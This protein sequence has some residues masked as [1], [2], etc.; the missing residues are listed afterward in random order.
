MWHSCGL[1][2]KSSHSLTCLNT[3]PKLIGLFGRGQTVRKWS[4]AEGSRSLRVCV[5]VCECVYMHMC[6]H[7]CTCSGLVTQLYFL[8]MIY[9]LSMSAAWLISLLL[10]PSFLRCLL[11]FLP[12]HD[13]LYPSR[14]VSQSK[15][16]L[17][18]VALVWVFITIGKEANTLALQ[19]L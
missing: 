9:L 8:F 18:E 3:D 13:G 7:T 10:L 19:C 17:L 4:L 11:S 15:S 2:E 5:C 12:L 14:T 1:N 6:T 16:I